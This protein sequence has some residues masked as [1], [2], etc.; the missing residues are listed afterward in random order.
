MS[1]TFLSHA[2]CGGSIVLDL[3]VSTKLIAPSFSVGVGGIDNIVF[4]IDLV[5]TGVEKPQFSCRSCGN[6]ITDELIGDQIV[7]NCQICG[8][9]SPVSDVYVHR[10]IPAICS[11][12]LE[13]YGVHKKPYP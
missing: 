9:D 10:H 5:P 3:S 6:A 12:C 13:E 7:C 4:D 2:K 11:T 1:S 8:K